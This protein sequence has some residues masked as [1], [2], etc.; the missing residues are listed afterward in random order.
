MTSLK[1]SPSRV[2]TKNFSILFASVS[3]NDTVGAKLYYLRR[4]MHDWPDKEAAKIFQNVA[5]AITIDSRIVID[6]IVVPDI[7]AH[8]EA[9]MQD[10]ALMDMYVGK[11][12]SNQQWLDLADRVGSRVEDIHTYIPSTYTSVLVLALK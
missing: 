10:L 2:R 4:I 3:D 12:R 7:G 5:G 11:E 1:R 9:T 8:Y 6:E